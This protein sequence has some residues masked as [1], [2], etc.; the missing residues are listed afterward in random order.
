MTP[1][2][3]RLSS[4][5]GETVTVTDERRI[6]TID[7]YDL[8]RLN[9]DDFTGILVDSGC[10]QR[11]LSARN[12]RLSSWVRGGGRLVANGHPVR[13]WLEGLPAHRKLDFHSPDDLWLTA[14][15]DHPI[16]AGVDRKD[17][18]FR[19]GVP[20]QHS[21]ERL[22]EIGVAGFYAHAYLVDLPE[23]A[24]PITGIGQGRLPVDLS[25]PLGDGEVVVHIGND[26]TRFEMQAT[27]TANLSEQVIEYLER[28]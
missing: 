21:F 10:D 3:L 24:V 28:S 8:D 15:G 22:A 7:I 20:G 4:S 2:I 12:S 17:L 9:L 13:R 25:Y 18:L 11:F 23:A 26:L 5:P 27:T 16:W 19:T 1:K 14:V 6:L